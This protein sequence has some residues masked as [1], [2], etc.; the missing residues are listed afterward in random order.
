MVRKGESNP[1]A[2][3]ERSIL[4]PPERGIQSLLRNPNPSLKMTSRPYKHW[5]G[6]HRMEAVSI[7]GGSIVRRR[8]LAP[9]LTPA[10]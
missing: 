10:D 1:H 2:L 4:S 9:E 3:L 5:S 8:Q 7:Y 6:S